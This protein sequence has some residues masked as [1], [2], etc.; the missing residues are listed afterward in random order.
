MTNT[1]EKNQERIRLGS[2]RYTTFFL[3]PVGTNR[4]EEARS[5]RSRLWETEAGR[6]AYDEAADGRPVA[7]QAVHGNRSKGIGNPPFLSH[8]GPDTT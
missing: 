4:P 3:R 8:S 7:E 6:F 5:R 2:W 1:H